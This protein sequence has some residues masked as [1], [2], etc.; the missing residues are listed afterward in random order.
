MFRK[1][2]DDLGKDL[3]DMVEYAVDNVSKLEADHTAI[4]EN[5]CKEYFP[6]TKT[7]ISMCMHLCQDFFLLVTMLQTYKIDLV[8]QIVF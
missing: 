2:I 1:D 3:N 7:K 4:I 8:T 6:N 5:C